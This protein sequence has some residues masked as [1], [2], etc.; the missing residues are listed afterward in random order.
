MNPECEDGSKKGRYRIFRFEEVW[1]QHS[2]CKKMIA[3]PVCWANQGSGISCLEQC[4][5]RCRSR[6]KQWGKGTFSSIRNR[7]EIYQRILQDLYS[8]QPPW[9]FDEIKK[10]EDHLDKALQD[11]EIYWKQRSRENWL[12]WGD[13]NSRWFHKQAT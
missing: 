8:K 1:T 6:L 4:L 13:R 12:K 2:D 5:Q 7:I 3:D 9:D 10:I 11:D